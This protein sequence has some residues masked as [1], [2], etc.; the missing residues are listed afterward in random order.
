MQHKFEALEKVKEYKIDLENILGK[1]IKTL[2]VD[3]VYM[4][5]RFHN[6]LIENGI[7]SQLLAPSIPQQNQNTKTKHC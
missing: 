6:Y 5:L 7:T 3:R 1:T 4:D 2:R